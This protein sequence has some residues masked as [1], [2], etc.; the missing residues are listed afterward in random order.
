VNKPNS[1]LPSRRLVPLPGLLLA[2]L[3]EAFEQRRPRPEDRILITHDKNSYKQAFNRYRDKWCPG[4]N[5]EPNGLR[6]TLFQE[7][8]L[9]KF[10][11]MSLELYLGHKPPQIPGVTW[12]HYLDQLRFDPEEVLKMLRED[13]VEPWDRVLEPYRKKWDSGPDNVI[14]L[15]A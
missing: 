14:S 15:S 9:E 4:L 5:L 13:V 10:Y 1:G 8:I 3:A 7:A 2:I 11:G 12:R 6:R